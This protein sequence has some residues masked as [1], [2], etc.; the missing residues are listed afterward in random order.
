MG[1]DHNYFAEKNNIGIRPFNF[2]DM[3]IGYDS[4]IEAIL[5]SK[6]QAAAT[7][8]LAWCRSDFRLEDTKGWINS[9]IKSW[10]KGTS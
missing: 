7:L 1:I 9:R 3:T 5:E 2:S 4:I 6:E 10:Q 8:D